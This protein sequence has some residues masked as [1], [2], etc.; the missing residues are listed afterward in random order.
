MGCVHD[1]PEREDV[2]CEDGQTQR[3]RSQSGTV[4]PRPPQGESCA[5]H[6]TI[7]SNVISTQLNHRLHFNKFDF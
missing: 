6:V 2:G 5:F 7:E 4:P 3:E 1:P